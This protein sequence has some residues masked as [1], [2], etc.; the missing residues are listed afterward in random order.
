MNNAYN[1]MQATYV[2]LQ[3]HS[4]I[5]AFFFVFPSPLRYV[6]SIK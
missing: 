4:Y 1:H 3:L 5:S 2:S 6:T